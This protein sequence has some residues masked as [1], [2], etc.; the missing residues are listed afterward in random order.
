MIELALL[1]LWLLATPEQKPAESGNEVLEYNINWPSGLSLGEAK[2]TASSVSEEGKKL[3]SF[4]F[5]IDAAVPGFAVRDEIRSTATSEFCSASLEKHLSHGNRKPRERTDFNQQARVATRA[6]EGGGKSELPLPAC[7]KDALTFLHYLRSE[8]KQGR[9]PPPQTVFFGA[10]YQLRLEYGG[11]RSMQLGD[12]MV[13][14]DRLTGT[15]KGAVSENR[16]EIVV[17]RDASR[18]PLLVSLPLALGTF[19]MELVQ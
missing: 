5:N 1:S 14:A 11:T 15:V 2:L 10:P 7:A 18:T 6:T 4:E 8:L 3:L 16:F 13:Q 12:S 19:S 17:A 9:L